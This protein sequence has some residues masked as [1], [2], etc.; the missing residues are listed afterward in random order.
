M[1]FD[2]WVYTVRQK[3]E[4]RDLGM[5]EQSA[6]P[7]TTE[8]LVG[9]KASSIAPDRGL[10]QSDEMGISMSVTLPTRQ[11]VVSQLQ[12]RTVQSTIR[13]AIIFMYLSVV[14]L[15]LYQPLR[16]QQAVGR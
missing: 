7:G 15:F 8:K 14:P 10:E 1:F 5:V 13:Y 2:E 3:S 9:T 12:G 4:R 6:K 11:Q 16:R